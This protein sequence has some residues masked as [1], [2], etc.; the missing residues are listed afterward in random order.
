[1]NNPLVQIIPEIN[2]FN[3]AIP[4]MINKIN[5]IIKYI[6]K[7]KNKIL[8]V[9]RTHVNIVTNIKINGAMSY[10][11]SYTRIAKI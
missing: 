9:L 7:Y 10:E 4:I 1:M 8:L 5:S 3:G 11:E 2:L 6:V